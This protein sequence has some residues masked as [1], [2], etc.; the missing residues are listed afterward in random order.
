VK[1][2]LHDSRK[3]LKERM[4]AMVAEEFKKSK[5]DADF[6]SL[7]EKA[8]AKQRERQFADALRLHS[9]ALALPE[10]QEVRADL[11]ADSYYLL[12]PSYQG[13]GRQ[14]ELAE[15][16]VAGM[17]SCAPAG[18]ERRLMQR[19][20]EA[21][22][23]FMDANEVDQAVQCAETILCVAET[24]RGCT[25]YRFWRNEGLWTLRGA[26]EARGDH[27]AVG[28]LMEQIRSNMAA[29]EEDLR[30]ACPG[31][32]SEADTEDLGLRNWFVRAGDTLHEYAHHLVY[33][34]HVD[35]AEGLAIM[36]RAAEFRGN[37]ATESAIV[38]WTLSVEGD[39]DAS[40]ER[41]RKAM[42]KYGEPEL[43]QHSFKTTDDFDP[44]R[45][46]PGF[47]A[48]L[49]LGGTRA[50]TPAPGKWHG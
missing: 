5:P 11:V 18:E 47:L 10:L 50:S 35:K 22:R 34:A 33:W 49:G 29:L 37:A 1:R 9:E 13:A 42:A 28:V 46:D 40:L 41:L 44:V 25:D 19:Y 43:F 4:I 14:L 15:G 24:V 7:V 26:A 2:R 3:Q 23:G 45:N 6:R 31:L 21:A 27:E 32:R 12:S 17:P 39:R 16:I 20:W 48:V 36:R 30:A 8:I 38:A